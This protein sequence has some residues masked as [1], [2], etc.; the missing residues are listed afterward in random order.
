MGKEKK[1][2]EQKKI[3]CYN[4]NPNPIKAESNMDQNPKSFSP[5]FEFQVLHLIPETRLEIQLKMY[6][7]TVY[8]ANYD[9]RAYT[10]S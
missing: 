10:W 4:M 1:R 3:Y 6:I 8:L 5:D 7:A 9:F 2:K